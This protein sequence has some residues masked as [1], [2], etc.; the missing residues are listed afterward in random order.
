MGLSGFFIKL[1]VFLE[2]VFLL[3]IYVSHEYI[4]ATFSTVSF[5]Y[6]VPLGNYSFA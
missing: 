2:K 4:Y 6:D 1:V 3:N 5:V